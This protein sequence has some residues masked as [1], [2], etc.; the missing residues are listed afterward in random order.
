MEKYNQI[1]QKINNSIKLF[2]FH[3]KDEYHIPIFDAYN[4][5]DKK[6][7]WNLTEEGWYTRSFPEDHKPGVYFIFGKKDDNPVEI[8]VYV[9]K[10]SFNSKIG[11][12]LDKH[13]NQD[14]K[15]DMIYKM[16]DKHENLFTVEYVVTIPM[17]ERKYLAAALEEFLIESLQ[18][19]QIYLINAVGKY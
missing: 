19:Q 2:S 17:N 6:I 16:Y 5:N 1:L 7:S 3:F 4:L 8:G 13:L 11:N 15:T 14:T 9:G 18:E 10:D 12:R